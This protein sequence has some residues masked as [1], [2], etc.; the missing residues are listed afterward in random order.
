MSVSNCAD[1]T[2]LPRAFTC[3][4]ASDAGEE[5]SLARNPVSKYLEVPVSVILRI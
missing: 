2:C 5:V 4:S 3:I 1:I